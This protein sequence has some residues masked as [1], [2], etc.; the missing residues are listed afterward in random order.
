MTVHGAAVL[1]AREHLRQA[2]EVPVVLD[3]GRAWRRAG[4][5]SRQQTLTSVFCSHDRSSRTRRL[6]GWI[7]VLPAGPLVVPA[8][9]AHPAAIGNHRRNPAATPARDVEPA[10][11]EQRAMPALVQQREPMHQDDA[12]EDLSGD[13]TAAS[14]RERTT[15]SRRPS[16]RSRRPNTRQPWPSVGRRCVSIAGAGA[17]WVIIGR[18]F[19]ASLG[20][21]TLGL[22]APYGHARGQ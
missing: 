16:S 9:H 4:S 17:V 14:R 11:A 2:A 20:F 12:E 7:E 22:P 6:S 18:P 19:S 13:P 1:G 5:R 15:R 3:A 10:A 8:V 21:S